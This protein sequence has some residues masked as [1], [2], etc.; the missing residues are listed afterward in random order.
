MVHVDG[1]PPAAQARV[2][3]EEEI[4]PA[5]Q[6]ALI[7]GAMDTFR[8]EETSKNDDGSE[9]K[10]FKRLSRTI[11]QARIDTW[12]YST[13]EWEFGEPVSFSESALTA[14]DYTYG[15]VC[16]PKIAKTC[17]IHTHTQIWRVGM[18]NNEDDVVV[19]NLAD[20]ETYLNSFRKTHGKNY[21]FIANGSS[22]KM[23][24]FRELRAYLISTS[25]KRGLVTRLNVSNPEVTDVRSPI[26]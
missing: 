4:T 10:E 15:I 6:V 22:E 21:F 20:D 26:Q 12:N 14:S 3:E 19:I 5:T 11:N 13:L 24:P 7:E 9:V 1:A 2:L 25:T 16:E 8:W 23:M 18:T 17:L